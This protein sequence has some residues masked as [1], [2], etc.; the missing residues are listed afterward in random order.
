[1]FADKDLDLIERLVNPQL[2]KVSEWLLA[3]KLSLNVSKSNFLIISPKKVVKPINLSINNENLKQENYTKYLGIIIDEKLNWKQHIK[4]VNIKISIGIGILYKL[5]D[6]LSP[7]TLRML[8]NYFI[9]SR[10]LYGIL[11]W[12]CARKSILEPLKRN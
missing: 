4:E 3:N 1:M 6:I 5:F 9:Q 2:E 8:Y 10:A 11:N 7:K 12:G